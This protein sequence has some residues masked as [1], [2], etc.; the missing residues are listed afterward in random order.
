[1]FSPSVVSIGRNAATE[2]FQEMAGAIPANTHH[3]SFRST[4]AQASGQA[5]NHTH[6]ARRQGQEPRHGEAASTLRTSWRA[7]G[8]TSDR[9]KSVAKSAIMLAWSASLHKGTS[10]KTARQ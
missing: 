1:M 5:H 2:Q 3:K 10:S 9:S 6:T 4:S 7:G 8:A